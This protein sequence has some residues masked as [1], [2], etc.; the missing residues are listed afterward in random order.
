M[1]FPILGQEEQ[2]HTSE[3]Q[4]SDFGLSGGKSRKRVQRF[5]REVL[6]KHFNICTGYNMNSVTIHK[7]VQLLFFSRTGLMHKINVWQGVIIDDKTFAILKLRFTYK[8]QTYLC[9][10]KAVASFTDPDKG[11]SQDH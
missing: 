8:L 7:A 1:F 9:W 4:L 2:D 11:L 10:P 6:P 5:S 3:T